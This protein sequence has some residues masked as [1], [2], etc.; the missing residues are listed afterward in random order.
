M[1]A[2]KQHLEDKGY[3]DLYIPQARPLSAGETLGCT[4]P[5]LPQHVDTIVFV[6]DGRFHL[7]ALLIANPSLPAFRCCH[8]S[9][10]TSAHRVYRSARWPDD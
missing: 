2:A 10:I 7:E 8:A 1:Q 9:V 3:K 6:A 4:A 5:T